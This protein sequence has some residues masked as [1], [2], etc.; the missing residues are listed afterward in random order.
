MMKI[1]IV[2]M[3]NE[4]ENIVK[5]FPIENEVFTLVPMSIP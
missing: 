4:L 5:V 2:F 1:E 3:R